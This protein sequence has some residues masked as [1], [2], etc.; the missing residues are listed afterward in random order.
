LVDYTTQGGCMI[1]NIIIE[2]LKSNFQGLIDKHIA[3]VNV[4][5]NSPVGVAEHADV[6]ETIEKELTI[7]AEYQDKLEVLNKYFKKD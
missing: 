3:N 1:R 4:F 5:L 2:G 6:L 7:V